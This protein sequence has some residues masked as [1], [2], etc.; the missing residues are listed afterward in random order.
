[1]HILSWPK[2]RSQITA[3]NLI[4][5]QVNEVYLKREPVASICA[6]HSA[7]YRT[8]W[9]GIKDDSAK[10]EKKKRRTRHGR[11]W[12]TYL[13]ILPPLPPYYRSA[14]CD[15]PMRAYAHW[16]INVFRFVFFFFYI[17]L[18]TRRHLRRDIFLSLLLTVRSWWTQWWMIAISASIVPASHRIIVSCIDDDDRC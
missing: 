1:M 4:V 7:M 10:R 17:Y 8:Q 15:N 11:C 18:F 13:S 9:S 3:G 16:K 2:R 6:P 5:V 14:S 12:D